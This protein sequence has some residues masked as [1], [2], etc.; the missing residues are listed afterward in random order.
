MA[1]RERPPP[2]L[3]RARDPRGI[4]QRVV[5]ALRFLRVHHGA[6]D[7]VHGGRNV[8]DLRVAEGAYLRRARLEAGHALGGDADGAEV[9]SLVAGFLLLLGPFL[10]LRSLGPGREWN[11]G[12][13]ECDGCGELLARVRHVVPPIVLDGHAETRPCS[14]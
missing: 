13:C 10:V 4:A 1:V 7:D 14:S 5:E 11:G 8:E 9:L 3:M 12:E 6:R 2:A